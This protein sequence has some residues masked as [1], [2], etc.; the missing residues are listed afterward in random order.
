MQALKDLPLLSDTPTQK[1]EVGA[2]HLTDLLLSYFLSVSLLLSISPYL[3][4][5][6]CI[7]LSVSP[8]LL[9]FIQTKASALLCHLQ[10]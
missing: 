5:C 2:L 10:L 6:L 1:R 7:S 4:L 8:F 3:C 9:G